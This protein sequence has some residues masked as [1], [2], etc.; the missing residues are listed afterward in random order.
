MVSFGFKRSCPLV[1]ITQRRLLRASF[2]FEVGRH[3]ETDGATFRERWGTITTAARKVP[4]FPSKPRPTCVETAPHFPP[5]SVPHFPRNPQLPL[6]AGAGF[7]SS[8][9][10]QTVVLL[11]IP[12][13]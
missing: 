11:W 4:H 1:E 2:R 13:T 6:R 10:F 12:A 9:G 5:K 3:Y 8:P 7:G